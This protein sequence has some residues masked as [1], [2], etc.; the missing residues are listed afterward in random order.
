MHLEFLDE[1]G[2]VLVGDNGTFVFFHAEHAVGHLDGEVTF[3]LTLASKSPMLLHLFAGEVSAFGVKDFASAFHHLA[4]ALSAAAFSA[5]G[6]R[7]VDS[8][9]RKSG[10]QVAALLHAHIVLSVDADVHLATGR[11]VSLGH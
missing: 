1:G 6:R 2:H 9:F 10:E 11:E 8:L 4:F 5:A 3:Y 7:K